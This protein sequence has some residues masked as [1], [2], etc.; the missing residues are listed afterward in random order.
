[1]ESITF[2]DIKAATQQWV[3][4]NSNRVPNPHNIDSLERNV[5]AGVITQVDDLHISDFVDNEV[6]DDGSVDRDG[7]VDIVNHFVDMVATIPVSFDEGVEP[8]VTTDQAEI[9]AVYA[10]N[11]DEVENSLQDHTG[12]VSTHVSIKDAL[13]SGVM[14]WYNDKTRESLES[15]ARDVV[16][17]AV[18]E[19]VGELYA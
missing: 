15:F 11:I 7:A 16:P 13:E 19:V 1:M 17:G 10:E 14:A 12:G 9:L 2:D 3:Q 6:G 18:D 8:P 4:H 5:I